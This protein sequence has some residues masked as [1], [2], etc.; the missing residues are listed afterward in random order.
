MSNQITTT[1]S[2]HNVLATVS[3]EQNFN[4]HDIWI[5]NDDDNVNSE[6]QIFEDIDT[7]NIV[8]FDDNQIAIDDLS[9][10]PT[11]A[12]ANQSENSNSI[13]NNKPVEVILNDKDFNTFVVDNPRKRLNNFDNDDFVT[14]KFASTS[15][16]SINENS[17]NNKIIILPLD[18]DSPTYPAETEKHNE[19]STISLE[20]ICPVES[21]D[22]DTSLFHQ[23]NSSN[24]NENFQDKLDK[25]LSRLQES[26]NQF[27]E[28][29]NQ[30]KIH[31]PLVKKMYTMLKQD[32][33]DAIN[34]DANGYLN[35]HNAVLSNNLLTVKRQLLV[36]RGCKLHVDVA[37]KTG[38]TALELAIKYEV[39]DE[40][41]H[42]LLE[43]GA[44]PSSSRL[45]HDSSLTIACYQQSPFISLLI[46]NIKNPKDLDHI[47]S[48]GMAAIHYCTQN[49]NNEAVELLINSGADVN[50]R[51]HKSGKTAVFHSLENEHI[52]ITK[53]LLLSGAKTTIQNY[54]GHNLLTLYN[55]NKHYVLKKFINKVTK[56]KL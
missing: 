16:V 25:M 12:V 22:N 17:I 4:Y 10:P 35:I 39:I 48:S 54:S 23:E 20:N 32:Y 30:T 50:L 56:K 45:A 38:E 8:S 37:A 33:H 34:F 52:E 49:G 53:L 9:I 26:K 55:E 46:K 7:W 3:N 14:K 28:N 5:V 36:L 11:T 42:M 19:Q 1:T 15:T 13:E 27:D 40:I 24:N 21:V 29:N 31:D 41:I 44:D 2:A 51:D 18:E 43:A 47:D 6:I